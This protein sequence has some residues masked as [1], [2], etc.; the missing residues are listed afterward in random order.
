MS[1]P[2]RTFLDLEFDTTPER[3]APLG[4]I[5]SS[6]VNLHDL[7]R[8]L[9]SLAGDPSIAEYREIQVVAIELRSPLKIRVSLLGIPDEAVTAFQ[10]ICREIIILR[11]RIDS[12]PDRVL[13]T[14]VPKATLKEA[15]RIGSH[16]V[17]LKNAAVPLRRVVR[18]QDERAS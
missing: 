11:E 2:E 4:D 17:A 8:D 18:V 15:G 12:S 5:A 13:D 1:L 10:D 7:L 3:G 9:A 6:L 16:I 14:H